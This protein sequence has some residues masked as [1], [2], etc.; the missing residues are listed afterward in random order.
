[1]RLN[2]LVT[3]FVLVLS[4]GQAKADTFSSFTASGTFTDPFSDVLPLSG[5]ITV[6]VTT[7]LISN[8]SLLLE[9]EFWT[10]II[11]QG[12]D[13]VAPHYDLAVQTPV[14]NSDFSHDTL[15]L[16]L[17]LTPLMLVTEQGG[18]VVSGSA[19]LKD[20]GFSVSL[21]NTGVL[22]PTPLPTSL[23]LFAVGLAA[24]GLLGLRRKRNQ[25]L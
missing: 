24:M 23:P 12:P 11:S 2:C 3:A 9:G 18:L 7:G 17:S 20:A 1:M 4:V 25:A 14:L 8:A 19:A 10:N 21:V 6:D 16:V 15:V 22:L 5:T 13:A